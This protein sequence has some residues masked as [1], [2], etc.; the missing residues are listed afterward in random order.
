MSDTAWAALAVAAGAAVQAIAGIGFALVCAPF[1]VALEGGREG[2]RTAILLSGVL[3]LAMLARHRREARPQDALWLLVPALTATPLLAAGV[4]RVPGRTLEVAAGV[5]TL[6][7]VVLLALGLRL[8][9]ARGR[10]GAAAAGVVSAATNVV[11]GIG[12]PPV[13]MWAVNADW[14]PREARATLQLYFLCLNVV[15]LA[16]LGMPSP[17]PVLFAAIAVGWAVGAALD[18]HVRD[19]AAVAVMLVLAAGG[20]V[21]ALL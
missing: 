4:R 13:A 1:L 21:V 17:A 19:A 16:G 9:A 8:H 18:R 5:V 12:G 14:P 15:A 7:A 2:V 6:A 10:A 20:A 3:N 11:A